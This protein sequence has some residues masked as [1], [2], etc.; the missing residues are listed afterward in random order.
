VLDR[1]DAHA[2]QLGSVPLVDLHTHDSEAYRNR[3]TT[4]RNEAA[5]SAESP[6]EGRVKNESESTVEV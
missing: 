4:L 1:R 6:L 5:T 2:G 3:Q